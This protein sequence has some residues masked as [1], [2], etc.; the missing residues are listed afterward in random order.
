MSE[1]LR[2]TRPPRAV[3]LAGA[4]LALEALLLLAP[5]TIGGE[6]FFRR[7]V[8]LMWST[9]AEAYTRAWAEGSWPL[10]SPLVSFGQPLLADANNQVL[11]PFTL[12]HLALRPWTFYTL[13]AFV[14]LTLAGLGAAWLGRRLGLGTWPAVAAGGLWMASGPLLSV[15][16][17][18]NQLAGAAWMPWA[19]AAGLR[20]VSGGGPR[21]ALAWAAFIALQVLAGSPECVLLSLA[22]VAVIA[23]V[24]VRRGDLEWPRLRPAVTWTA[25]AG[26]LSLGLAAA[27]WVPALDAA[28]RAGR[29][30]LPWEA[31]VHWSVHPLN[32][33]QAV[34]PV[35]LHRMALTPAARQAL[36][37]APDPFLPSI[38]LGGVGAALVAA[39]LAAPRRRTMGL[40][41]VVLLSATVA[42]GRH[43][44]L[45]DA[46]VA[47]VPPLQAFR[48]PAK[49]LLLG[50]LS[51]SLLCAFGLAALGEARGR[52]AFAVTAFAAA[53]LAAVAA[54]ALAAPAAWLARVVSDPSASGPLAARV[55]AAALLALLAGGLALRRAAVPAGALAALA[56]LDLGLAHH[57][58]NPTAPVAL[59]T[60]EPAAVASAR[61]PD[62][63]RLYTFDYQEPGQS[64]LHLGRDIPYLL[65]RAPIGWD[66][67][68][69]QALA[70]REALYPPAPGYSGIEGSFDRDV[71]GLEPT[72]LAFLKDAF[73]L[74]PD[75]ARMRLLRIAAVSRVAALH[76]NAGDGLAPLAVFDGFFRRSVRVFGVPAPQRVRMVGRARVHPG[77]CPRNPAAGDFDFEREVV[78]AAGPGG[79]SRPEFAGSASVQDRRSDRIAIDAVASERGW[80]VLVDAWDPGWS[81]RVDGAPAPLERANVAFRAV[82]IPAGRHRVELRYRPAGLVSALAVSLASWVVLVVGAW[83]ARG[84][85]APEPAR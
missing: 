68:S 14:H 64:R 61:D 46:L 21:A 36:F 65:A 76:A 28:R 75:E 67:R 45:Y 41:A 35:P 47:V 26:V 55:G 69:A 74:A 4:A 52:R 24:Q 27:Q 17:T 13:Y 32:L 77:G 39:S 71:P 19:M 33:A 66:L 42:M 2:A 1:P 9:Q 49:A 22:G 23:L 85:G 72:P 57:D 79:A 6:T 12:L 34:C 5:A 31:R 44:G 7:D 18:W 60:H 80:L 29:T 30:R 58:L 73:R 56:L 54:G 40:A 8:H 84:G 59:Y 51:W 25:A 3:L 15:I 43:A 20:T 16:D 78:L 37:G 48:Y 83:L 63:G 11:Y 81:A 50:S 70:L 62:G 53:V 38:Y 82:P 10:W